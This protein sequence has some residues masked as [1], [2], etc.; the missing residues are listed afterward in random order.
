MVIYITSL[1]VNVFFNYVLIF[2]KLGAPTLG[3]V[4]AAIA[5]VIARITE[6]IIVI[7]YLKYFDKKIKI[8]RN[9]FKKA[10]PLIRKDYVQTTT[11]VIINEFLW[12]IGSATISI[13]IGRLGTEIVAANS[14][15]N[16][17]NQFVTTFIYALSSSAAVI[18]GNTIGA[19]DYNKTKQVTT[20]IGLCVAMM[21]IVAGV[22]IYMM[23]GKIVG[24]YNVSDATK[25]FAIMIMGINS[26]MVFF[27]ALANT[28]YVGILRAGGDAK[29]VLINDV[30]FMWTLAIPLGFISAF[31]WELPVLAIF[32]IIR[33]DEVVKV[34]VGTI[35]VVSFKWIRNLTR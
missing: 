5:T 24:L 35:R 34:I 26:V 30:I 16:V 32:M 33:I 27:Q 13:I 15:A 18:I 1:I 29:F 6:F 3:A 19:G 25:E 20:T 14:I 9:T 4:G 23:R 28:I 7:I 17:V 10:D 2:G 8:T 31:V 21:G 12:S 22:T 11:P